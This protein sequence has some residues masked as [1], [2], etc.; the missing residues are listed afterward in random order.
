MLASGTF[1]QPKQFPQRLI[2]I[3]NTTDI[4][5]SQ[6]WDGW[7]DIDHGGGTLSVSN[8]EFTC[9]KKSSPSSP[10]PQPE[11]SW[12]TECVTAMSPTCDLMAIGYKNRLVILSRK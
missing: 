5:W 4:D 12:L 2:F 7:N 11:A 10:S 8:E 6:E 1:G 3:I 9:Q